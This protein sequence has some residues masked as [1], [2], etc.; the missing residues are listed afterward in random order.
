MQ[1]CHL[2]PGCYQ[3]RID[4]ERKKRNHVRQLEPSATR[5]P[6]S[7]PPDQGPST[8]LDP[9][10]PLGPGSAALRRVLPPAYSPSI[11]GLGPKRCRPGD[12]R[13]ELEAEG[14]PDQAE[15]AVKRA[16]ET[17]RDAFKT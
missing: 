14:R 6:S 12:R 3:T 17:V 8:R 5:P 10:N 13:Q 11:F 1:Q 16:A 2:G 15:A 7:P 9:V 4:T